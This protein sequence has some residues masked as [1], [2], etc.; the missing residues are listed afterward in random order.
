MFKGEKANDASTPHNEKIRDDKSTLRNSPKSSY[1]PTIPISASTSYAGFWRRALADLLDWAV[2]MAIQF[3]LCLPAGFLIVAYLS[4]PDSITP[5][6]VQPL[7]LLF[8]VA[9]GVA[10]LLGSLSPWLY[11]AFFESSRY[12]G[13]FGKQFAGLK[14][15]NDIGGNIGF[16]RSSW[17]QLVVVLLNYAPLLGA[18]FLSILATFQLFPTQPITVAASILMWASAMLPLGFTLYMLGNKRK[19]TVYDLA[20]KRLVLIDSEF[21]QKPFIIWLVACIVIVGAEYGVGLTVK[22]QIMA[23]ARSQAAEHSDKSPS[24]K[25]SKKVSTSKRSE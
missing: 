18:Q 22:N 6:F 8:I 13:T 7:P 21:K 23:Q 20:S 24:N 25:K 15:T 14:V 12:Q 16:W 17:K 1:A 19:Q 5:L 2:I 11:I 3:P 4:M 10:V 9:A